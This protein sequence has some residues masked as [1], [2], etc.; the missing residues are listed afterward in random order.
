MSACFANVS[1][2]LFHPSLE[3]QSDAMLRALLE[4]ANANNSGGDTLTNPATEVLRRLM[5]AG[6]NQTALNI[7]RE[8]LAA[9]ELQC[10][11]GN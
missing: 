8:R 10:A 4:Y 11:R 3:N 1:A 5:A 6:V 7:I 2:R 9:T